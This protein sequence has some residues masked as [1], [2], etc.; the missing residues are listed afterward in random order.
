MQW[1][2]SGQVYTTV[3]QTF[4]PVAVTNPT[5]IAVDDLPAYSRYGYS[6]RTKGPGIPCAKRT[7]MAAGYTGA[8]MQ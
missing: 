5:P 6:A 1:P 8:P 2:I 7:D 3:D 4:V